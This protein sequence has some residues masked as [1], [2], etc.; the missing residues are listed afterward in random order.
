MKRIV[1]LFT[2]VLFLLSGCVARTYQLTQDRVDQDLSIGNRGYISG[3]APTE[4]QA[5]RKAQ[6]SVRIFEFELGK[7]HQAKE[8]S[9][10][11][12]NYSQPQEPVYESYETPYFTEP[13]I[14][15]PLKPIETEYQRYTVGKNDTLQ[16]ISQKFYGTTKKWVKIY[17]AN[18]DTLKSP[19]RLYPGQTLN[20]P[21]EDTLLEDRA[22]IDMPKN[23]K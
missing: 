18:K 7:P 8:A 3:A 4:P 14:E 16:K 12:T 23:L 5:P 19:D 21:K 10:I 1:F 15:P 11:S 9:V 13:E 20:I 22:I 6:R 17:N 2:G